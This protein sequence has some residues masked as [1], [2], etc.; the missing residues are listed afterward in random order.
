MSTVLRQYR[1]AREKPSLLARMRKIEGQARG[2]QRM[3]EDDR[4]CIDI[5]QQLTALSAAVDEVSLLIMES[6]IEG[7]VADAIRDQHGE[8]HIKELMGTIRKA[9][10]W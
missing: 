2:I 4:Y 3:I 10:K 1:Y 6:H 7:C 8:G 9:L 5:V